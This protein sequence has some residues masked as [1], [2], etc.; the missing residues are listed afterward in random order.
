[1]DK[2]D[3][4]R[5]LTE[6]PVLL[7]AYSAPEWKMVETYIKSQLEGTMVE[8]TKPNDIAKTSELRGFIYGLRWVL[9]HPVSVRNT[10]TKLTTSEEPVD[11][12][13]NYG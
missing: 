4:T 6:A 3:E 8:L 2:K 9:D 12:G 11:E 7:K 10:L 1:M 13:E 5:F